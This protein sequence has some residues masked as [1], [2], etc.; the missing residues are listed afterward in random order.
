[1][2]DNEETPA[3]QAQRVVEQLRAAWDMDGKAV[4][5]PRLVIHPTP[6]TPRA[7]VEWVFRDGP[8][9]YHYTPSTGWMP[10]KSESSYF[11]GTLDPESGDVRKDLV[12]RALQALERLREAYYVP[13]PIAPIPYTP[14]ERIGPSPLV[15]P[16]RGWSMGEATLPA[17]WAT[18]PPF[19][20]ILAPPPAAPEPP[21]PESDDTEALRET[22]LEH[23]RTTHYDA[24]QAGDG[25]SAAAIKAEIERVKTMSRE[26]LLAWH[27]SDG[28]VG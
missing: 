15:R 19:P 3:A 11:A 17:A 2:I 26:Q 1:M 22:A 6:D 7:P 13:P 12:D 10:Y 21:P 5:L 16:F 20:P 23:L 18:L 4:S 25:R 8:V 28:G 27:K 14:D 24:Q 9:D